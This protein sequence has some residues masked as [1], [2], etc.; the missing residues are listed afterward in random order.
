MDFK[1][2]V[3][4]VCPCT[5]ETRDR[6]NL[7]V[8]G[9]AYGQHVAGACFGGRLNMGVKHNL[10]RRTF[11][12]REI[13]VSDTRVTQDEISAAGEITLKHEGLGLSGDHHRQAHPTG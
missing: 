8:D 11:C 1:S 9:M 5:K 10:R 13:D 4:V 6:A 12:I 7:E 2:V 3:V